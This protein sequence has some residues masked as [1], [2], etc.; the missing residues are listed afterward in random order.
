MFT[1]K[2]RKYRIVS[3]SAKS[4]SLDADEKERII[5]AS[6]SVAKFTTN[7]INN[8]PTDS[9]AVVVSERCAKQR[10]AKQRLPSYISH[11]NGIILCVLKKS[12]TD[13]LLSKDLKGKEME[14]ETDQQFADVK[15]LPSFISHP[16]GIVLRVFKQK[17]KKY[18]VSGK[19]TDDVVV[20]ERRAKQRLETKKQWNTS[21][22]TTLVKFL[23]KPMTDIKIKTEMDQQRAGVKQRSAE[24]RP[25]SFI[26]HP[27]GILLRVLKKS[28]NPALLETKKISGLS[29]ICHPN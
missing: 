6:L 7:G 16:I 26:S 13:T 28:Y 10:S 20:S 11:Q 2:R 22:L 14:T 9:N 1:N 5:T 24:Q 21:S 8:N 27:N 19:K 4:K 15:R 18:K 17:R 29:F 12:Y 3:L 23:N 25:P